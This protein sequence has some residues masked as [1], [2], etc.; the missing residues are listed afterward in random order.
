[1]ALLI[2]T[3]IEKYLPAMV[4]NELGNLPA[5]KQE[6]FIEEF[7]RKQ[8]S[9][10]ITYILLLFLGAHYF[11]LKR[12]WLNILFWFTGGGMLIWWTI[13]IF[14]VP[15]LIMNYN[16]DVATDTMRNLKAIS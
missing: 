13:D 1:M 11:Y 14:R 9:M 7:K 4:R 2:P 16:K 12:G 6:E 8:K 5:Q 3:T 10:S 15:S